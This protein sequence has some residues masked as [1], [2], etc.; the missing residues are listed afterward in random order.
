[1]V[2]IH[3]TEWSKLSRLDQKRKMAMSQKHNNIFLKI[4]TYEDTDIAD[5]DGTFYNGDLHGSSKIVYIDNSSS[6]GQYKNGRVHGYMR[7]Y[8]GNGHMIAAGEYEHG[9]ERGYH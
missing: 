6:L 2:S 1:M 4:F 5:I 9:F 3:D 8:D 7:R